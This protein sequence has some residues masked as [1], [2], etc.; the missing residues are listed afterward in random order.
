M[1]SSSALLLVDVSEP[2]RVWEDPMPV[3]DPRTDDM[4]RPVYDEGRCKAALM[5]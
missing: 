4:D 2:R 5:F 1:G 3:G